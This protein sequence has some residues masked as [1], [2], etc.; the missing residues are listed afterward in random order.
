M[1]R[2]LDKQALPV[3]LMRLTLHDEQPGIDPMGGQEV[4]KGERKSRGFTFAGLMNR[5][6][7]AGQGGVEQERA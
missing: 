6:W 1:N 4:L 3:V 7:Q 2:R 5:G